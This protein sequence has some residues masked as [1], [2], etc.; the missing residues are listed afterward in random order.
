M[1]VNANSLSFESPYVGY[2]YG[3]PHKSAYRPINPPVPLREAWQEEDR[4]ALFLYLHVPFCEYRCGFC[5]LFTLANVGGEL[6]DAYLRQLRQQAHAVKEALP[7]AQ[8]VRA[9]IGGGTPTFFDERQLAELLDIASDALGVDF[10]AV[11]ASIEASPA[12]VSSDKLQLLRERGIERL[13]LGVQTFDNRDSQRLGRPQSSTEAHAAMEIARAAGFPILNV[14]L[15]YGGP[16]Q[17]VNAWESTVREALAYNP[18]EIYLYPLYVRP[19]TGLGQTAAEPSDT[20]LACYRLARELLL[21]AGY[22]QVSMRMFRAK[23]SPSDDGPAYCCQGDGMLGLGCGARSYT[24]RLHYSTEFA[25]GRSGVRSIFAAYMQRSTAELSFADYGVWLDDDDERRRFIILG[26]L[27]A[28]GLD[29]AAYRRRF[30]ADARDDLPQ[31]AE[32]VDHGFA[33]HESDRLQ[34]TSAGLELSD[35]IGP[36]LYSTRVSRLMEECEC[37]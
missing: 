26:L 23:A 1:I 16:G 32:L 37:H 18:E 27:Q 12:T 28:E 5:N 6:P 33:N 20:R 8:F 29:L 7:D 15:I 11:P 19:L 13:S 2:A 25:V 14:D 36:W 21:D 17:S 22:S 30:I 34:L 9:A 3:Y 10:R 4:T 31:L 35:A 24:R